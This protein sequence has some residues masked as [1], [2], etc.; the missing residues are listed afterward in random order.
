MTIYLIQ[1]SQEGDGE[2]TLKLIEKFNPLL[3]KYAYKLHYD[4]SYNDLLVDFITLIY[5]IRLDHLHNKG[6]GCIVSYMCKSIRSSFIK[7]LTAIKILHNCSLYSELSDSE[8]YYVDVLSSIHDEYFK[9]DLSE[10]YSILSESEMYIIKM[11]YSC[12]Y[13]VSEIAFIQGIS[14][15]AVNQMK[16]RALK[17]LEALFLNQPDR[18]VAI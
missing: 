10:A 15:Q 12:G 9:D 11:V 14:R 17:K 13:T 7:K 2:A 6:E 18:E 8:L 1:K 3:R 5:N 16:K 4:D